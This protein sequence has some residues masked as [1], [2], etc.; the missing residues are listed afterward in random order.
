MIVSI[1]KSLAHIR[2]FK[3]KNSM[4]DQGS[5]G[6][7]TL[8]RRFFPSHCEVLQPTV[9]PRFPREWSYDSQAFS[10]AQR[11]PTKYLTLLKRQ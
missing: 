9:G 7:E 6:K 1:T 10:L 5:R 11:G 8:I 3:T 4:Y 2:V